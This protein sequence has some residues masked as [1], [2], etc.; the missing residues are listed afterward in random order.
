MSGAVAAAAV[1]GA[2][3]LAITLTPHT[4]A[5][6]SLSTAFAQLTVASDG[7]LKSSSSDDLGG[8]NYANQWMS[9][10]G[11]VPAAGYDCRAT[12]TS[13]TLSSG[14]AGTWLNCSTGRTWRVDRASLGT[15]ACT[16]TLEIRDATTLAVLATAT[17]TVSATV[18]N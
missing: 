5:S 13:G 16:F 18:E 1:S 15:K 10:A 3:P 4:V 8:T 17:M 11:A 9:P 6:S 14:T 7:I 2:V 12:V